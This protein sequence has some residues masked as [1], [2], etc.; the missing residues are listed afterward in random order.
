V[1][2]VDPRLIGEAVE[3]LGLHVVEQRREARG[4]LLGVADP[5]G[6]ER[7]LLAVNTAILRDA[8]LAFRVVG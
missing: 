1:P 8:G 2:G 6:E 5:A 4:V 7:R 3:E